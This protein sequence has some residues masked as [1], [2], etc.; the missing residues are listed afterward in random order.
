MDEVCVHLADIYKKR[1]EINKKIWANK[2]FL[3]QPEKDP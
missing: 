3:G 1:I 2:F